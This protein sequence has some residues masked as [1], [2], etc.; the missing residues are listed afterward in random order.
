MFAAVDDGDAEMVFKLL[1][2]KKVYPN[3]CNKVLLPGELAI[4]SSLVQLHVIGYFSM[5]RVPCM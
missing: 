3:I 4:S 2:A 5:G 1:H